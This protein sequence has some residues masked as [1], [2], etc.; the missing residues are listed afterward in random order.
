MAPEIEDHHLSTIIA[1]LELNAIEVFALDLRR[2]LVDI[3]A[4]DAMS[5][6]AGRSFTARAAALFQQIVSADTD[7]AQHEHRS[8]HDG[9]DGAYG[10]GL[11][12]RLEAR[13]RTFGSDDAA[14]SSDTVNTVSHLGQRTFLP[15]V[16]ES[17]SGEHRGI[18][19]QTALIFGMGSSEF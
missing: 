4:C 5:L 10:R 18:S 9:D 2:E 13:G 3:K 12:F 16:A 1:E 14:D 7:A 11:L 6:G 15:G 19:G 8:G 17:P